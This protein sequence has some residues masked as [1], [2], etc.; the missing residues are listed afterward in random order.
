MEDI[1]KPAL[2]AYIRGEPT[3]GALSLPPKDSPPEVAADLE[4]ALA[5]PAAQSPVFRA[6]HVDLL[7]EKIRENMEGGSVD[8]VGLI[9]SGVD[10]KDAAQLALQG[11][12]KQMHAMD[13]SVKLINSLIKAQKKESS[14]NVVNIAIKTGDVSMPEAQPQPRGPSLHR[15][16]ASTPHEIRVDSGAGS[17]GP[18]PR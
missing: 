13:C 16:A 6:A 1:A 5:L 14:G 17:P 4:R 18:T 9:K 11:G 3:K 8:F 12:E 2:E 15:P 10:P 7:S